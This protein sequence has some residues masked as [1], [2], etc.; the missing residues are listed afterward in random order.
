[1]A[2]VYPWV[3]LGLRRALK[4]RWSGQLLAALGV[5]LQKVGAGGTG[6]PG[7]VPAGKPGSGGLIVANHISWL[8]I[9]VINALEPAAFV[10]K[11]DVRGWPLI[12]WLSARTE[13]I[14][15]ERGSRA[16]VQ[17]T[18]E[19]ITGQLAAGT[20][21]AVFPEGTTTGG[22]RVLPFHAAL[23]QSAIDAQVP[24]VPV[25]LRYL[26]AAGQPCRA[27]AY[28]GDITLWQSMR[29]IARAG[30]LSAQVR[31]LA[32]LDSTA[33]DRRHLSARTHHAIAWHL[34]HVTPGVAPA[35]FGDGQAEGELPDLSADPQ[36]AT[37]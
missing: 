29:S 22:D 35:G 18:R 23:F 34:G 14:F 27:P 31:M 13:T 7:A 33:T 12:G 11:D 2:L 9:Y 30:G 3:S 10:S 6:Q 19:T 1:V 26:D 16:A 24:V 21:V 4:R 15:L 25:A 36:V 37:F 28:D 5:R 17:R 8:D 20:R 32:P